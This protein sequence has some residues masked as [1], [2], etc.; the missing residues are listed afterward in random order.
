VRGFTGPCV[1]DT[2]IMLAVVS[3]STNAA[4]IMIGE[5]GAD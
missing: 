2:S 5:E 1:I 3:G 4:T